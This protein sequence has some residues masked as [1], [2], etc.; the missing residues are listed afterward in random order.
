MVET[1]S[2][3]QD[4]LAFAMLDIKALH[5]RRARV[6][7]RVI[8]NLGQS[9]VGCLVDELVLVLNTVFLLK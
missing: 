8:A 2:I 9:F 7:I 1:R 3:N 4:N 5:S 6:H